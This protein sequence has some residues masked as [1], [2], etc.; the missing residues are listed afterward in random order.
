MATHLCGHNI[1]IAEAFCIET[2]NTYLKNIYVRLFYRFTGDLT[3]KLLCAK[4]LPA[5]IVAEHFEEVR[6]T[7]NHRFRSIVLYLFN[8]HYFSAFTV[9]LQSFLSFSFFQKLRNR[10]KVLKAKTTISDVDKMVIDKVLTM[11]FMSS[12][13]EKEDSR[14]NHWDG[15]R[16]NVISTLKRWIKR[17][18]QSDRQK[19]EDKLLY[20][21][22]GLS[23]EG[24]HLR[25]T[26][27][28]HGQ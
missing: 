1:T 8:L 11:D 2:V 4:I 15:V 24:Q 14:F 3:W 10:K 18:W 16:K 27:Q 12:E 6:K 25:S 5:M 28:M 22:W 20:A 21:R 19:R 7:L 17:Q 9:L 13:D 23:V 26:N